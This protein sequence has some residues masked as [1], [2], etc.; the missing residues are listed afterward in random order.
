MDPIFE[1]LRLRNKGNQ[2]KLSESLRIL[3]EMID[4]ANVNRKADSFSLLTDDLDDLEDTLAR[5]GI[6]SQRVR[7]TGKWWLHCADNML[8]FIRGTHEQVLL[9][10]HLDGYVFVH[11][12]TGRRHV[13]NSF[14]SSAASLLED[15]A[16]RFC[17]PLPSHPLTWRD[18]LTYAFGC[19]TRYEVC[20]FLA[21]CVAV[22][23]LTMLTPFATNFIF[24]EVIPYGDTSQ[25]LPIA[26]L[27]IGASLSLVLTIVTRSMLAFRIKDRIESS[28]QAAIMQRAFN[29][30]MTFHKKYSPGNI[31]ERVT[32][33]ATFSQT[34]TNAS[35]VNIVNAVFSLALLWQFFIYGG[36]LFWVGL[37]ALV[38]EFVISI[39]AI[40]I[41]KQRFDE[42]ARN[43]PSLQGTTY[44]LL[45]GIMKIKTTG[46]EIR[47]FH[48]WVQKVCDADMYKMDPRNKWMFLSA[49]LVYVFRFVPMVMI[50]IGAWCV[51]LDRTDYIAFCSV[52]TL[53]VAAIESVR[54]NLYS[55]GAAS[56]RLLLLE[57][58]LQTV[59][60]LEF[61][62]KVLHSV[63]GA[64]DIQGLRFRYDTDSPYILDGLTLTIRAGEYIALVGRSGCG[65]STILRLLL[66]FETPESGT[67][68]FD[69]HNIS[70][71]NK[72]SLRRHC[73]STCLQDGRLFKGSIM[74][75]IRLTAPFATEEEVWE[76]ARMA[77]LDD[78]IR[79]MPDG[80]QTQITDDGNGV[81][82]GQLQRILIAR[83][84]IAKP[85][86]LLLDEATSALDNI[87]QRVVT[88]NLRQ[89]G[90]T[91]IIVA[92]RLSTIMECDRI[93]VID[94]GKV[95]Q[96]G[97]YDELI[98]QPGLFAEICSRQM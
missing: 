95:V 85:Q 67:I 25:I 14:R 48:K 26:T 86:V 80:M 16:Y 79:H 5:R 84:V 17:M 36:R 90:C 98:S 75:N 23:L 27:L 89:M 2:E 72:S 83:S 40:I 31:T 61:N 96:L 70:D 19:L 63:T 59:P 69:E 54:D 6:Y 49:A 20:A 29:L 33:I 1:Q 57:P 92:H 73:V 22:I 34:L 47:A 37:T 21:S 74:D 10:Q 42:V 11:P 41:Y 52:F 4:P 24:S 8:G 50:F 64:I 68:Y 53:A 93:A 18:L 32:S 87:S 51:G 12:K 91:R 94:G 77:A 65:K 66:G 76:A 46:A 13:L 43:I 3:R 56:S 15:E 35:I 58:V 97:S 45:S 81:S 28:L 82:G 78:D 88:E 44:N 39:A 55:F 30:P 62:R 38:L 9:R 7:I 60:E 71:V